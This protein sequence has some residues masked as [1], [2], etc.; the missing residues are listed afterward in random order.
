[1][2]QP[3]SS[4][5]YQV[6]GSLPPDAPSY[7]KRQADEA[8]YQALKAG[9][10]C[11]VLNSRQMG[12]SSLRVR[13]MQ[14]LQAEGVNCA[15]I[16]LTEIG[17][18]VETPEHWYAGIVQALVSSSQL[19]GTF[20]WRPWW[21]ERNLIPP[22]Q[23]LSELIG[24]VMLG[25]VE[26][27][28]VIFIDEIDSVLGLKFSL[29]DF[30]ALIRACY[31][32]RVDQLKYYRLA[33]ALFGV[34]TPSDLIQDKTWT[35]FNVGKAVEL[36]GFEFEQAQVLVEGVT[37]K[38]D[39][40]QAVLNEILAWTGGQPFLTQKLCKLVVQEAEIDPPQPPFFRGEKCP[41][42]EWIEKVVR[43]HI[44]SHWESQDE[45]EHLKTIR[46]RILRNEQRAGR[47]LGL[48]QQILQQGGVAAD[49]SS[50]QIEM[51]LS[52]L[53]VKREGRLRISNRIYESVFDLNWVENELA[54]LRPYSEAFTAWLASGCQDES[55][56]LRRQALQDALDWAVGKN[57][58]NLDYQFLAASQEL[59]KREVQVALEAERHARELE[60]REA[61]IALEAAEQ[62]NQILAEA[63]RKARWNPLKQFWQWWEILIALYV[64]SAVI[65]L[66]LIGILQPSELAAFDELFRLR[67]P[68][69]IDERIIIVDIS[70]KDKQQVGKTPIS[71][72]KIAQLLQ[73]LN[74]YQP[75]A[76]GLSIYRDL[77]V[78]PG[79]AEFVKTCETIPNLIGIEK[80]P[81]KTSLGIAPPSVLSQRQQIG[82]SNIVV[83]SDGKVRRSLLYWDVDGK[84]HQSFALKLA[85]IYLQAQKI[86]PK[87]TTD[88]LQLDQ[89]ILRYF[90]PYDGGYVRADAE[91]DQILV[92]FRHPVSFHTVSL[93]DV[94]E[95]RVPLTRLRSHIVLI[96][97]TAQPIANVELQASF[98]SQILSTALN[99]RPLINVWSEP[100]EWLWIF[101]WSWI[102]AMLSWRLRSPGWSVLCILLAGVG[103]IVGCYIA[104]WRAWWLPLVSPLLTLIGGAIATLMVASKQLE[105]LELRRTLELIIEVYHEK[106]IAARIA[107]EYLKY[108]QSQ[109]NKALLNQWLE[110]IAPRFPKRL[111]HSPRQ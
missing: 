67:P 27:N 35:P 40:P 28:L 72:R 63:Q 51:R 61:Q 44:I 30:F 95:E 47:L 66:S 88:Y 90:K 20:Q 108:S 59:D 104:F 64:T 96:G 105:K 77:P 1:M 68:E 43:S 57:L 14:R 4:Y 29:D 92:N 55:R 16:D 111:G 32:K 38:V 48:Y 24:E 17:K 25:S 22:V 46:D 102:G 10:F 2:A 56:L 81:D 101:G 103:L 11:Y 19:A 98:I 107:I 49:D 78:E 18:Q 8:L 76:I 109:Q 83:D 85:L 89:S 69:P 79:N 84:A 9:E 93:I 31:N 12:K 99:Q 94:L 62:A 42:A 91:G 54:N 53:V 36:H 34:A 45:P 75:R 100:L 74:I 39:N 65:I 21:R 23:R 106:P 26:Q 70:E 80:L 52:G 41:I 6:G 60:K 5:E 71:D 15:F 73:K 110:E 82:F 86:T 97:S 37:G 3:Q 87:P 7:V 33:F 13:T 58:S 50:E